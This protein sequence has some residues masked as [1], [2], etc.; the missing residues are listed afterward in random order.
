MCVYM[1][2]MLYMLNRTYCICIIHGTYYTYV[3]CV[4]HIL[5]YISASCVTAPFRDPMWWHTLVVASL[6][7]S[8][9]SL[10]MSNIDQLVND[11]IANGKD[12]APGIHL[13]KTRVKG[14]LALLNIHYP[15]F[16]GLGLLKPTY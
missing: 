14:L 7:I 6:A 15:I 13:I 9:Q 2:Y 10:D 3:L 12:Y 4:I 5:S 11:Q 16:S 1:F 8:A